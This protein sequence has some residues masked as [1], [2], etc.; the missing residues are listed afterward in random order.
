MARPATGQ[1][2]ERAG[3]RGRTFAIRFTTAAGERRQVRLGREADGWTRRRAEEELQ[4]GVA[5]LRRGRPN[6]H[7]EP[8]EQRPDP[9]F[10]AF[11]FEWF[12]RVRGELRPNTVLDYEWQL[13]RHLLPW[14][15]RMPLSAIT[16]QEVDR[17][18][19]AKVRQG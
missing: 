15:G 12:E 19:H 3:T 17:Y 7:A 11:A 1:V 8:P 18:R 14:F 10:A 6:E 5:D 2:V 4:A 13:T 16:P 9:L